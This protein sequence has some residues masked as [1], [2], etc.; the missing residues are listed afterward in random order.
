MN[1]RRIK[2]KRI[3][4]QFSFDEKNSRHWES[5][6]AFDFRHVDKLS[7]PCSETRVLS[8]S[9]RNRSSITN[10][11]CSDDCMFQWV[12]IDRW[13]T[14]FS[15]FQSRGF[16]YSWRLQHSRH[17]LIGYKQNKTAI[18]FWPKLHCTFHK[19]PDILRDIHKFLRYKEGVKKI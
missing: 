3:L 12:K 2:N 11:T 1:G 7:W 18:G 16:L 6:W 4:V 10:G 17:I 5:H 14:V 9:N 19:Y 8:S 15:S 13:A